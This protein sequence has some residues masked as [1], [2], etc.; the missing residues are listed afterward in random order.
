MSLEKVF[1]EEIKNPRK[2]KNNKIAVYDTQII[3]ELINY[4][5]KTEFPHS[6]DRWDGFKKYF[7]E[8]LKFL[9]TFK[10]KKAMIEEIIKKLENNGEK[11]QELQEKLGIFASAIIQKCYLIGENDFEFLDYIKLKQLF[12]AFLEGEA[13]RRIK[14]KIKY[15]NG[16][17]LLHL[18]KNCDVEIVQLHGTASLWALTNSKAKIDFLFGNHNFWFSKDSEIYI[19]EYAGQNFGWRLE[20]CRVFSPKDEILEKLK[21]Q[22]SYSKESVFEIKEWKNL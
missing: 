7:E 22:S 14:M 9:D 6:D 13:K 4:F 12:G 10:I 11:N 21:K 19:K 15:Y 18:A 20:K 5:S 16:Y 3:N 17:F 2:E 1:G 8:T